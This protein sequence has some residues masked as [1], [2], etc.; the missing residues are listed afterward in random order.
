MTI[1]LTTM[2]STLG[3]KYVVVLHMKPLIVLR[4]TPIPGDQGLP[5][6]N[7]NPLK[8]RYLKESRPK[9]V[10]GDDSSGDTEGYGSINCN[11]ITFTRVAYVNGLKHNLISIIQLCDANYKVLFTKTQGTIYNQNDEVVLIAPRRRDVYVIDMSSFNKESNAYFYAKASSSVNW[12]W[13]KRLS[14]LNFKNINNLAKH[15]LVSGLPSLTFFKDKNY[16][17]YEKGKHHSASFKTKRSFSINKSIIVKR[18]GKTSYDVLRGRSPDISYFYVFGCPVHIHNHKDPLG[19]FD[20][21]ADDGFFLG[22]SP[23]VKAFRVFNIRSQEME[24]T[25]HVTF[26][27][28]DEAISQ[29]NTKGDAINFNENRSFPDDEFLEPRS[30]VTQCP[31]N[32]DDVQPSL[33]ICPSAEIILQT[34]VPQDRWSREKHIELV[35]IIGEPLAG[36][37]TKSRIRDS[38]A[39]SASKCLYVNVLSEMEPKKLVKAL[40]EEEWIIAMQEELNQFERNKGYNQHEGIDYEEIFIPVA[41][42]E[43]IRIFLAYTAYMGFMVYQMDVKSAFLNGKILKEV[44]VQQPPG[45][46][47]SEYPNH[48][49]TIDNTLFTYKTKSD[50][51]IVHIYVDD[52]IFGSTS[53]ELSKQFGKL[54]IKKY[55]MSMMGELTY[56]MGFQIKQNFKGIFICQEK[57]VKD[58]LKKYDLADCASV[59]CPMLPSNNLGPDESGVFV[60]KTLFRGMIGSL[61]YLTASRHDIKFF[62]CLC[63]RYQANTKESHLVA[64]KRI[65]RYLKGTPNISLWYPKGSD[66][67]LKAYSDSDY[68]GSKVFKKANAEGE[69]WEKNNPAKEKDAQRP[70]QT[71]G[72]QISGAN[73]ADIVQGEQPSAQVIINK[74]KALVV[75]NSEEKKKGTVSME[76]DSDDDDLDKNPL[77]KRFK[78]MTPNPNPIPLNTFLP[79]H[80]LKP[81]E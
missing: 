71:K 35:N 79:K 43:A 74:E 72:E 52:I 15:N 65:F 32:I 37:T 25:L 1:T 40:E 28:D 7:Q 66:F 62:T 58:L 2:S 46:E 23:V 3:V 21:K 77:S 53:L 8:S 63:A 26:S 18:H 75:H 80:L 48:V 69:K 70:D 68:A 39:A 59:K 22:Y 78:I 30:V 61:M 44:Y 57:Y 47:R 50:V 54:M 24:E 29:S 9:V 49:C 81:E 11:G 67:D 19:K 5:T 34:P 51:M 73:I 45:F 20:E 38:D 12:L 6:S 31:G 76:N 13:H 64:V 4:N 56:F 33:T 41:R 14:H 60:N 10:F 16:S 17:A 36:I 27:E 55:E 42:L